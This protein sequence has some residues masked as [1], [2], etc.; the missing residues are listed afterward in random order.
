MNVVQ[1]TALSKVNNVHRLNNRPKKCLEFKTPY[2]V[3]QE[4]HW[5]SD[6]I[7]GRNYTYDLN[8]G[9]LNSTGD[10]MKNV[11]IAVFLN[12]KDTKAPR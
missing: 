8:S 10:L 2:E 12:R 9:H 1:L 4:I 6:K 5:G 3:F 7:S 11:T